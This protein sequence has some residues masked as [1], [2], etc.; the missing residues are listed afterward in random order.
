MHISSKVPFTHLDSL[1]STPFATENV[2]GEDK[3]HLIATLHVLIPPRYKSLPANALSSYLRL[4]TL[5]I[6]ATPISCLN[7]PEKR[8]SASQNWG[9]AHDLDSDSDSESPNDSRS[10]TAISVTVVSSFAAPASPP[11]RIPTPDARILKRLA[12][13]PSSTHIA[14]LL[15]CKEIHDTTVLPALIECLLAL[16]IVWPAV[17]GTI[18]ATGAGLL[19]EVYR[20]YVRRSVLGKDA[21][22][23]ATLLDPK[24]SGE[25]PALL[26]LT[27]MYA[28]ALK[29]MGDDEFFGSSDRGTDGS[30]GF[31]S[32]SHV[33]GSSS[34][35]GHGIGAVGT[36]QAQRNPLTL[37]E[38]R[39]FS[40]QLLNIAFVLYWRED[41]G[42]ANGT[43]GFMAKLVGVGGDGNRRGAVRC[44][45]EGVREKVTRCLVG[46]HAR[47]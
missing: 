14:A 23:A 5:L 26:F 36:T 46:I 29:T 47:E 22:G 33:L 44:T 24:N 34:N 15:S 21:D 20:E 31:V 25:W 13:L 39:A 3:I 4:L 43:I 28:Q 9:V 41:G 10:G 30:G 42:D 27:D 2:S 45:W 38:L 6:N 11:A 18:L 16:S 1:D 19:R 37:D 12:T 35:S 17:L 7:H 8:S 32:H 40:R